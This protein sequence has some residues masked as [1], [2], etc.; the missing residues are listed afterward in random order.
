MAHP[1]EK[2]WS[3]DAFLGGRIQALQPRS[4]YRAGIDAVLLA[5]AVPAVGGERIIEAGTG[6]G[7]AALCLASRVEN[8]TV[9]GVEVQPQL[10]EAARDNAARNRLDHRVAVVQGDVCAGAKATDSTGLKPESFDRVFA[11]PP[12]FQAGQVRLPPDPVRA[13]SHAAEPGD[14]D[15]WM[16]FMVSMVRPS[17]TMTLIHTAEALPRLLAACENRFGGLHIVPIHPRPGTAAN[18]VVL[19]GTKASRA[20]VRLMHGVCL[21]RPDGSY[22]PEIENVLRF[23]AALGWFETNPSCGGE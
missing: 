11:N 16:R 8:L 15:R 23:G 21:H 2:D 7:V 20:P 12:Y 4:G 9:T 17:G 13:R 1:R 3:D 5:A 22:E 14:L 18:R 10:C 19:H 6:V